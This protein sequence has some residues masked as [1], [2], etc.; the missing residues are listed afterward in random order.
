MIH[1]LHNEPLKRHTLCNDTIITV[2]KDFQ[3]TLE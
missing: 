3:Y 1:M 2:N